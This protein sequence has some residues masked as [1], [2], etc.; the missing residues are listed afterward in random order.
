HRY[1]ITPGRLHNLNPST[2]WDHLAIGAVIAVPTEASMDARGAAS[3]NVGKTC[4]PS[5]SHVVTKRVKILASARTFRGVRYRWGGMSRS[6]TDC[7]GF[8]SQVFRSEG[9]KL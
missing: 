7:S 4:A 8:T 2:D 9:Y 5:P 3:S 6:G 1:H